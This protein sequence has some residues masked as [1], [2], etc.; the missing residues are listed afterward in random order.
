MAAL[1]RFGN[2]PVGLVRFRLDRD[3]LGRI[4]GG[5]LSLDLY[6]RVGDFVR[7]HPFPNSWF[8]T[9]VGENDSLRSLSGFLR[10]F[11]ADGTKQVGDRSDHQNQN[12]H[13]HTDYDCKL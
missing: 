6:V 9:A 11:G 13:R 2:L 7:N 10:E 5:R 4:V 8:V 12:M 3:R 1:G